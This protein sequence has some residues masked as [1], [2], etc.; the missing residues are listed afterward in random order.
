MTV[1]NKIGYR[2]GEIICWQKNEKK[3][4]PFYVSETLNTVHCDIL[5]SM[6]ILLGI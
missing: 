2:E 3:G 4:D 6:A 1:K 5:C